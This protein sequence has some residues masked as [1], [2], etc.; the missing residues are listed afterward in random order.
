MTVQ[1]RPLLQLHNNQQ[2]EA[3]QPLRTAWYRSILEIFR[4]SFSENSFAIPHNEADISPRETVAVNLANNIEDI[5]D[6]LGI[7]GTATGENVPLY[8]E[9]P[10]ILITHELSVQ[11][12]H[13]T[14]T[15]HSVVNPTPLRFDISI[16]PIPGSHRSCLSLI[17]HAAMRTIILIGTPILSMA[18]ANN[19]WSMIQFTF[20][21]PKKEYGYTVALPRRKNMQS[22]ASDVDGPILAAGS[23]IFYRPKAQK[24]PIAKLNV[25]S[26]STCHGAYFW[27]TEKTVILI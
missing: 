12:A 8:P 27:L 25:C 15:T 16:N 9:F 10:Q 22:F 5:Y 13:R 17:A 11:F 7:D 21:F 4:S 3:R 23:M 20:A 6:F 26:L 18:S 1:I 14:N 19:G 24:L 2:R